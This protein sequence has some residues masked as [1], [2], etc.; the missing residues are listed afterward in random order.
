MTPK[1]AKQLSQESK[2]F[3]RIGVSV[4]CVIFGFIHNE[5]NVLLIRSDLQ[6]F[7]DQ[8]SLLGDLV[9][10]NE[11]LDKAAHR[12]LKERTGLDQVFL[13]QAHTFGE[14]HRHPAGRVI[15]IAYY[16]LVNIQ[17]HH[18]ALQNNQLEWHPVTAI[19][20]MAFDHKK[21]LQTCWGLL[22]QQIMEH[23]IVFHLLPP[24]FSLRQLQ[25][26][27]E[28]IL[29]TQLDRRNFRKRFFLM[30]WIEEVGELEQDVRHRP[31][32]LYRFKPGK[33]E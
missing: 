16:A 24:K 15:T 20:K 29:H 33:K 30:N 1:T 27:Y 14:V 23:P 12:I 8:L 18:L 19:K 6:E 3:F 13:E 17:D 10:P 2:P 32:K 11:D 5:L 25:S 26:L 9:K 22:Q 21:I 28:A 7:N 31:G 4:D